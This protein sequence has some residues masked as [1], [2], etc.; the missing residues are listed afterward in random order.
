MNNLANPTSSAQRFT[1]DFHIH[2][3][4]SRATSKAMNIINLA[5]WGQLK[6]IEVMGTGDFTHP[7]WFMEM[8]EKLEEAEPGLYK[9]KKTFT[10]EINREVPAS[11]QAEQRFLLTVE[12]SAIYSKGNKVRKVHVIVGA[13]SFEVAS[14]INTKLATIG[15][16]Q[17]DGRP[18][19]GIDAKELFKIVLDASPDCLFIPAHIWTPHFGVLGSNS[20]FDSLQECFEELTPMIT[21]LETGLSSDP[22]MGAT[23]SFLKDF[24]FVSN[25]DAHSPAKLGREVN[26]FSTE[27]SYF[28]IRNALKQGDPKQFLE[29]I[30][31]YP[32][33]GKY[34]LDGHRACAVALRP[35]E[36]I[37]L[38]GLCPK[39]E[40]KLTV[41]VLHRIKSLQDRPSSGQSGLDKASSDQSLER[42]TLD[43]RSANTKIPF[44]YFVPLPEILADILN[45]A[46][47]SKKVEQEYFSLLNA[48]GNE[49]DILLDIPLPDIE[50]AS[51]AL[52]GE[53]IRRVRAGEIFI[54]PGYDGEYGIIRVFDPNEKHTLGGQ[55]SMF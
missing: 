24:T 8:R 29:T 18:I 36:T 30:E 41:G 28:A 11:C 25:S 19:L 49:F 5:K 13:P 22:A 43:N 55:M 16:L 4:F 6:G 53:A 9:L 15:N 37:K 20:G 52:F 48:L 50:K 47:S 3:H 44:R 27:L 2:S 38:N 12:I 51:S 10:D 33:E 17:A 32:E 39:C 54:Q 35:E 26:R 40:K 1:A 46:S 34:F 23:C 45:S 14:K 21:A 7:G 42:Q 31:F